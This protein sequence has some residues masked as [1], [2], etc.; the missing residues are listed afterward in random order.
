MSTHPGIGANWFAKHG[1]Q[2]FPRDY[3]TVRGVKA[4][5][6]RYY[7]RKYAKL[8]PE[9]AEFVKLNRESDAR[10]RFDDNTRERLLV[11]EQVLHATL[12]HLKRTLE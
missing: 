2:V 10:K 4:N 9:D 8:N 5:P 6:P 12:S 7:F 1:A 3:V 11:K